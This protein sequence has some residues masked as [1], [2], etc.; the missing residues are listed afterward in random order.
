MMSR[1][2]ARELTS[3]NK[4]K[5]SMDGIIAKVDEKTLDESPFAYKDIETVISRQ[6]GIVI[7]VL[8]IAKPIINIKA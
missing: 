1:K 6:E 2:K 8:D 7:D 3:L 4:F 5:D